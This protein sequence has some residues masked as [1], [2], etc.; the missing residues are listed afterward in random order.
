MI[1]E[2]FFEVVPKLISKGCWGDMRMPGPSRR[3]SKSKTL[4]QEA[5]VF[6]EARGMGLAGEVI[7]K[8]GKW[9]VAQ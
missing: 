5:L 8:G 3:K 6:E 7:V 1:Q 4:S 9:K 2:G